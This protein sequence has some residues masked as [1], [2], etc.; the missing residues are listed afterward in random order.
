MPIVH[1]KTIGPTQDLEYLGLRLNLVEK[2]LHIPQKKID[3]CIQDINKFL[4]K[5]LLKKTVT[6]KE[7]QKLAGQLCFI[8]A[9]CPEGKTYLKS[10]YNLTRSP[11]GTTRKGTDKRHIS[12]EVA[13]DLD[14][15]KCFLHSPYEVL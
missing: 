9:V 11:A 12:L 15:F 14:V 6:V 7:V 5:R 4:T 1:E 8:S 10:L 2:Q 13:G 3:R